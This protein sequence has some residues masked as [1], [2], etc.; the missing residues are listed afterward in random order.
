V[1]ILKEDGDSVPEPISTRRY[2]GVFK[3]RVPPDLDKALALEATEQNVALK[4]IVTVELSSGEGSRIRDSVP[5]QAPPSAKKSRG[6][7]RE[8]A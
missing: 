3:A 5:Q 8:S 1:A 4:R 6:K 7:G 2:S